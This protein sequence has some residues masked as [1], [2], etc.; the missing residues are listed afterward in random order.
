MDAENEGL[1]A[2]YTGSWFTMHYNEYV[3]ICYVVIRVRGKQY[4][5]FSTSQLLI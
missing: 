2:P 3:T 1:V 4:T 5:C